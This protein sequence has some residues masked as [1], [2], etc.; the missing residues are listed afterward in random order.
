[1]LGYFSSVIFTEL[2]EHLSGVLLITESS[3]VGLLD[4]VESPV[5]YSQSLPEGLIGLFR[6]G[7]AYG[8]AMLVYHLPSHS[9]L[10]DN[11]SV[12]LSVPRG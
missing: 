10:P 12:L 6:L 1:M 2:F 5:R 4:S 8:I 11:L 9:V 7:Y 3:G